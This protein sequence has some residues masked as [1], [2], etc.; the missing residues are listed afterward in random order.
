MQPGKRVPRKQET[1]PGQ[2]DVWRDDVWEWNAQ[3]RDN[4]E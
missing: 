4:D 2:A 1:R 3:E